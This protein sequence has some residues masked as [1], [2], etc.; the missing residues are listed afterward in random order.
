[1]IIFKRNKA[2]TLFA[3][4]ALFLFG[5]I[6][7]T[8]ST[9]SQPVLETFSPVSTAYAGGDGSGDGGGGACDAVAAGGCDGAG[10]GVL[11]GADD[12]QPTVQINFN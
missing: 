3:F 10:A 1:M 8:N 6:Y 11:G 2:T 7:K 12:P 4:F 5:F 9:F